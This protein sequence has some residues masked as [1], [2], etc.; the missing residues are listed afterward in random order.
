MRLKRLKNSPD[1]TI[2][3]ASILQSKLCLPFQ[4]EQREAVLNGRWAGGPLEQWVLWSSGRTLCLLIRPSRPTGCL[5]TFCKGGKERGVKGGRGDL[6]VLS[7]WKSQQLHCGLHS[8]TKRLLRTCGVPGCVLDAEVRAV[9]TAKGL[10]PSGHGYAWG[11]LHGEGWRKPSV[12]GR[13]LS[14]GAC[15][16]FP[17]FGSPVQSRHPGLLY[18]LP[19]PFIITWPLVNIKGKQA[20]PGR[21]WKWG[22]W[23][24][25]GCFSIFHS[26]SSPLGRT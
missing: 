2:S 11:L 21:G 20:G 22:P 18:P 10:I 26:D 4:Q 17:P 5:K 13:F 23:L 25:G 24:R 12:P 9:K 15:C 1:C 19:F 3:Y 8:F 7:H 6:C 16:S 14:A